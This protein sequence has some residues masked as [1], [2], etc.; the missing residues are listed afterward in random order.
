MICRGGEI[1]KIRVE[2][3]PLGLLD[4]REYEEVTFQAQPGDSDGIQDQTNDAE[5][6]Y[7][8]HRLA[9][10]LK[11]SCSATPGEIVSAVTKDLAAFR[12]S[13]PDFDDQTLIAIRVL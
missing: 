3:V 10:V 7:G 8:R 2:G 12:G 9:N 11:A 4:A 6:E 13:A 5:E 1:L